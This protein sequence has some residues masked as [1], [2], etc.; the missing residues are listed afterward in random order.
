MDKLESKGGVQQKWIFLDFGANNANNMHIIIVQGDGKDMDS[1]LIVNAVVMK[2][3]LM[4]LEESNYV[5]N[6]CN[7]W[8]YNWKSA[9]LQS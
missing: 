2:Q 5:F 9:H 7:D 8:S 1:K 6:I 4:D 3:T